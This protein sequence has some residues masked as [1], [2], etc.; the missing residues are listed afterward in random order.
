MSLGSKLDILIN[1][2]GIASPPVPETEQGIE[3]TIGVNYLGHFYLV[4]LL[5]DLLVSSDG[6]LVVVAS[7]AYRHA[8][9]TVESLEGDSPELFAPVTSAGFQEYS[10]SNVARVMFTQEFAKRHPSVRCVSLHP[11]FV[12]TN[13]TRSTA[14]F[15]RCMFSLFARTPENGARNSIYCATEEVTEEENGGYFVDC[16]HV[17]L[18]D[19]VKD[20]KLQEMLWD[21]SV[22]AIEKF[23]M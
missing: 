22:N 6:R 11:G 9:R 12:K 13:I 19:H 15:W 5:T 21:V 10:V 3:A 7:E 16:K 1:N 20:S 17:E 4:Q 2:A 18:L 23:N 8:K 14:K